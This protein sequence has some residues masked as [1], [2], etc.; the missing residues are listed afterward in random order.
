MSVGGEMSFD[1]LTQRVQTQLQWWTQIVQA[2]GG[3][4]NSKKCCC[5]IYSWTLDPYGILRL[6]A[7]TPANVAIATCPA[8]PQ[9]TIQVLRPN[10]G[11]RYLGIYVASSGTTQPMQDQ[12]WHKAVLYTKA[13]QRTHMSRRK[14]DVLY[15]SCFLPALTYAFPAM[16]LPPT[17]LEESTS[18]P[19]LRY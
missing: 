3:A 11:T 14:A 6:S 16:G 7:T 15:R 18:F 1:A 2:S 4:L 19:P 13:F 17:F 5:A 10:E 8:Q 12:L 9:Q